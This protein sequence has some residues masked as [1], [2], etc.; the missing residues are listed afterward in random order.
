MAKE[1]KKK[2]KKVLTPLQKMKKKRVSLII[3]TV[4][5]G[6]M[7][8]FFGITCIISAVSSNDLL[9]SLDKVQK[10]EYNDDHEQFKPVLDETTG[11]AKLDE[12]GCFNFVI[13]KEKLESRNFKV[14]QLTDVHIG[15]GAFSINNDKWAVQTVIDMVTKFKPDLVVVTGDIAYPVGIQSA[16]LN[17]LKEAKIFA[18][19]MEK[20]GVYWTLTFGNHDTEAYSSYTREQIGDFYSRDD[21][22]YCMF[23]P[24]PKDVDGVG[25][26]VINVKSKDG[27]NEEIVHSLFMID[28]HSYTDGD[29][30][31]AGWKYDRIHDN[32]VAWYENMVNTLGLVKDSKLSSMYFH[33]AFLEFREAYN[34]YLKGDDSVKWLD[35]EVKEGG[36][37]V[38]SSDHRS[39]MFNKIVALGTTKDTFCGHDHK[40]NISLSYKGVNMRYGMSIDYL[41]Y[42]GIYKET[43][44]RGCREIIINGTNGELTTELKPYWKNLAA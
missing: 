36:K 24:G 35:G 31:G 23:T 42:P 41:A 43:E 26:F 14:L 33:I 37:Y 17:N 44:H 8:L 13:D 11:K 1:R 38:Y 7:F 27:E 28:S 20:L 19:L 39:G 21:W 40:N 30:F 6:V 3:P 10:V 12:N 9:A 34:L 2:A 25:N 32:Q 18:T 29:I 16:S 15:A 4:I 5:F 22:K